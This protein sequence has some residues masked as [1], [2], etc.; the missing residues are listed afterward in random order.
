[1]CGGE[2]RRHQYTHARW[3]TCTYTLRPFDP[4]EISQRIGARACICAAKKRQIERTDFPYAHIELDAFARRPPPFSGQVKPAIHSVC[5]S[6]IEYKN[7]YIFFFFFYSSIVACVHL[8]CVCPCVFYYIFFFFFR[9][10]N[11]IKIDFFCRKL[12]NTK[13]VFRCNFNWTRHR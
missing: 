2:I 4:V 13:T 11:E 1:M 5:V 7:Y 10:S 9:S 6:F 8:R 3:R 12:L